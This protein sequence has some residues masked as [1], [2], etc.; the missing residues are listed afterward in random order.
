MGWAEAG[1]SC[2]KEGRGTKPPACRLCGPG[3][4]SSPSFSC[5]AVRKGRPRAWVPGRGSESAVPAEDRQETRGIEG[6]CEQRHTSACMSE[7]GVGMRVHRH[8]STR[9]PYPCLCAHL[10]RCVFPSRVVGRGI[11][12]RPSRPSPSRDDACGQTA[13]HAAA[14]C[15]RGNTSCGAPATSDTPPPAPSTHQRSV[16]WWHV[17][18][19][20]LKVGYMTE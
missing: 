15:T 2:T 13:G 4:R 7:G 16:H 1:G 10:V 19:I 8:R 9:V 20:F 11:V 3:S 12:V 14:A 6:P 5:L 18:L 17:R